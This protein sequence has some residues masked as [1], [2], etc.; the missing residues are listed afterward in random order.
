MVDDD[1]II[2][3]RIPIYILYM[4][5]SESSSIGTPTP[6]MKRAMQITNWSPQWYGRRTAGGVRAVFT[7][8][9]KEPLFDD[10]I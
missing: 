3:A 9:L 6:A 8:M 10:G 4:K 5:C 7:T 1:C 2:G